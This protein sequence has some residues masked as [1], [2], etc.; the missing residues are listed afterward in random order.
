MPR[1]VRVLQPAGRTALGSRL[2]DPHLATS[3]SGLS[4][5]RTVTA[6]WRHNL[7][8]TVVVSL[9]A[10]H[11]EKKVDGEVAGYLIANGA[12]GVQ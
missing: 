3:P 5:I 12:W 7:L 10:V 2:S 8:A 1:D 4:T 6:R 9:R 11:G